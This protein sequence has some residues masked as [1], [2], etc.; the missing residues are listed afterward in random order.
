MAQ[1]LAGSDEVVDPSDGKGT[2]GERALPARRRP[3]RTLSDAADTLAEHLARFR[4]AVRAA[5]QRLGQVSDGQRLP[6]AALGPV[7]AEHARGLSH[8][9]S[10][11]RARAGSVEQ[12]RQQ[13]LSTALSRHADEVHELDQKPVAD[14][15]RLVAAA[16]RLCTWAEL[17]TSVP[18]PESKASL[19]AAPLPSIQRKARAPQV[20]PPTPA[21]PPAAQSKPQLTRAAAVANASAPAAPTPGEAPP[22]SDPTSDP[23]SHPL[24]GLPGVGPRTAERLAARGLQR[25]VDVLYFLPRRWEDLRS[26]KPV[27]DLQEG[28]VQS[29]LAQVERSRIVPAGRRFLDVTARGEDGTPLSLRWFYFHGGMLRRL[30]PGQR[31]RVVGTPHR[32]KGVLQIVHP[33]IDYLDDEEDTLGGQG[34]I[35][36]RYPEVEGVPARTL[37]KLCRQVCREF[38]EA[39][40]DGL[41]SLLQQKLALPTLPAALRSLHLADEEVPIDAPTAP[42]LLDLLNQG[43]A[44]AQRRLIFEEL[45]FLQLGLM[46]RRRKVR[47]EESGPCPSDARSLD[48]L[49]QV[50]PFTPTRAQERAIAEIATDLA[51]PLPMQRLVHGD[52]GSGK[53][54]VAYAACELVMA[55]GR[56]AAIMAPTEILAEQHARTLGGWARAT[57][58]R[59]ALL[60][61]TT[62]KSPRKTTLALLQAGRF[63]DVW[64]HAERS[65]ER[66]DRESILAMLTV[67]YIHVVVGTH[68]LLAD[69]VEFADLGLV[70]IDEQHRFGVAQRAALRRKGRTPHLLVM[71][72]TPIPRTLALTLYGDLDITQLD[73]LPPGR[74]PPVTR[75]LSGQAGLARALTAV[76]RAVAAGRQAYWVCPLI[77]DSEKLEFQSVTARHASLVVALP[78]LRI[79]L[80]HGRLLSDERDDIMDRF[81]RGELHVLCATTV[82]E[83]GVDVPNASLMVIEGADRFG[84]AQLHQLRGRIGRGEGASACLLLHD[85]PSELPLQGV[86]QAALPG[87]GA[88]DDSLLGEA[89]AAART[90]TGKPAARGDAAPAAEGGS[91]SKQRLGVLARSCNGFHIAEADLR[92]R[93]PGEVLGTRQ[94]GLPPLRYADL[95]RDI[96]LLQIA[97]REAAALVRRDPDLELPEHRV[98]RQ[99]LGERW[100]LAEESTTLE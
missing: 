85:T 28:Q 37:E 79:G 15:Q 34:R 44:P 97:R 55:A 47:T 5:A 6:Q 23:L 3:F 24:V 66:L 50:L 29:T 96:D 67:G 82:I 38:A 32:F 72:A 48:A 84:L 80:V 40:P 26:L 86:D 64:Q 39:V 8:G 98:T 36:T 75:V 77:E 13:N 1:G 63:D 56:Q 42:P 16:Q 74:T 25:I 21:A 46:Q 99:L 4:E 78:E 49:R 62:P 11:Q 68:A 14:Q 51:R 91:G 83:V 10:R 100:A 52:V 70:V 31:L 95:L 87:T 35:R 33:E 7:L 90:A 19:S 12:Q 76:R 18:R 22:R 89:S 57:G 61:A 73:E 60:T 81:R 45:F 58:R 94:A 27:A 88:S 65:G 41:P 20:A 93:G 9:L 17:S 30:Q 54:L 2:E 71:T 69:R 53:T 43:L 92:M 59:L